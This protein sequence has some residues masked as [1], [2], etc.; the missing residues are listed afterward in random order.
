MDGVMHFL[1]I[2]WKVMFACVP[3]IHWNGGYPAFFVA[4]L[5]IGII[6]AIVGDAATMLG[7]TIPI[8][9]SITAITLVALGTS[10]PD[11]FASVTAA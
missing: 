4:L 1:L 7:C 11:T 10:L 2:T 8:K 3:P 9:D 6:T 5:F